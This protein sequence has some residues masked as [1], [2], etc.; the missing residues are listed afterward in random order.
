VFNCNCVSWLRRRSSVCC[1][2]GGVQVVCAYVLIVRACACAC[3]CYTVCR[4][5][6]HRPH[7]P[8][9][10]AAVIVAKLSSLHRCHR[11]TA[12][13]FASC[14]RYIAVTF[15]SCHRYIA[16]IVYYLASSYSTAAV[17]AQSA[18]IVVFIAPV[19]SSSALII[20][21]ALWFGSLMMC[22]V[23]H[24]WSGGHRTRFHRGQT[25]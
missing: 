18:V 15:A 25:A 4:R 16:G 13:S 1:A 14:H 19:L 3:A 20:P 5:R 10:R 12:V 23:S 7:G 17:G 24:R 11:C 6:V 21:P 9:G 22:Y 8:Q 2:R